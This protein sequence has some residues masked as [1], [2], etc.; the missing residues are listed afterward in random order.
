MGQ[1]ISTHR[2]RITENGEHVHERKSFVLHATIRG[3][4][5]A[6]N[7]SHYEIPDNKVAGAE[8]SSLSNQSRLLNRYPID[9]S[10]RM[11]AEQAMHAHGPIASSTSNDLRSNC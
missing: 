2:T 10:Q 3:D 4:L 11:F 6:W 8:Q 5:I 9:R 1:S 7:P